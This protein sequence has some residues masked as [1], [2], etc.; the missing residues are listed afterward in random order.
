MDLNLSLP[1][2]VA[3]TVVVQQQL[4]SKTFCAKDYV[5]LTPAKTIQF[6]C[7]MLSLSNQNL[8]SRRFNFAAL[9]GSLCLSV[10][11]AALTSNLCH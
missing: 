8:L 6:A 2:E 5:I 10:Q 4:P 3:E 7:N 1:G 11:V 9:D